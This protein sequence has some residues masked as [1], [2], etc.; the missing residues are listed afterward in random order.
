MKQTAY[1]YSV[2]INMKWIGVYFVF[3][4]ILNKLSSNFSIFQSQIS[5][6]KYMYY[7][8]LFIFHNSF[9]SGSISSKDFVQNVASLDMQI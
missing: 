4:L 3:L 2:Y 9:A 6:I 7:I 1:I 5:V 8:A